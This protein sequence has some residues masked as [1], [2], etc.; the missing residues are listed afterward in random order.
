MLTPVTSLNVGRSPC[1]VKPVSNP[2][3]N[4]PLSPPPDIDRRKIRSG[5]GA[6]AAHTERLRLARERT[7]LLGR[8]RRRAINEKAGV[9][10]TKD[11]RQPVRFTYVCRPHA[12][13]HYDSLPRLI[14]H[15]LTSAGGLRMMVWM[16]LI[17]GR[18]CLR[19][20]PFCSQHAPP[21]LL[22]SRG[23]GVP[24]RA[25][26]LGARPPGFQAEGRWRTSDHQEA[27]YDDAGCS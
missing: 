10:Q 13:S 11:A 27:A 8:D 14:N 9:G 16:R 1:T 18:R 12:S 25:V 21:P 19:E 6:A 26:H 20:L 22:K 23:F 7:L 15:S 24:R 4:A 2:A 17:K 3:P 5:Q